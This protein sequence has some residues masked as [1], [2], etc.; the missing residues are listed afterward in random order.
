M[1]AYFY[2]GGNVTKDGGGSWPSPRLVYKTGPT[3]SHTFGV[4]QSEEY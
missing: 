1:T 2:P 3:G 4:T